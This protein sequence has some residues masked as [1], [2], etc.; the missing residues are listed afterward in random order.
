MAKMTSE[1]LDVLLLEVNK[2]A[3]QYFG[4]IPAFVP[5]TKAE[6]ITF[7]AVRQHVKQIGGQVS[8]DESSECEDGEQADG[9]KS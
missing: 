8:V 2:H 4:H 3:L 9:K 1:V 6:L 5:V 7:L